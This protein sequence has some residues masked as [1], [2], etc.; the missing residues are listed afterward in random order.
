ML[1]VS[2]GGASVGKRFVEIE[3]DDERK[4]ERERM[5]KTKKWK[6]NRSLVT[7]WRSTKMKSFGKW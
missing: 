1:T 7:W 5:E 3:R 2:G 4:M 6:S